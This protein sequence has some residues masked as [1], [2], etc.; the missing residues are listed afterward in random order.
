MRIEFLSRKNRPDM[1]GARTGQERTPMAHRIS[2]EDDLNQAV[3]GVNHRD[4][5]A[6]TWHLGRA[7]FVLGKI[8]TSTVKD[9]STITPIYG[10]EAPTMD[11]TMNAQ[12]LFQTTTIESRK[13]ALGELYGLV[14]HIARVDNIPIA[15]IKDWATRLRLEEEKRDKANTEFTKAA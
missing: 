8:W 13:K 15:K 4:G 3:T 2:I 7:L 11:L 1:D 9:G 14:I 5:G 10:N 6:R 12:G